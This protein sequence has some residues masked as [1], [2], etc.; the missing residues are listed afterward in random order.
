MVDELVTP[1]REQGETEKTVAQKWSGGGGYR[2]LV[3]GESMFEDNSGVLVPAD[4]AT[5]G[6]LAGE[7]DSTVVSAAHAGAAQ[8][9]RAPSP[10][11]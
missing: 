1:S 6:A 8:R 5:N 2:H 9:V 3:V 7:R 4:W 11:T 10:L